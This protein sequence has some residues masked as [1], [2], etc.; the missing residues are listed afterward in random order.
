MN[1]STRHNGFTIVELLVVMAIIMLLLAMVIPAINK[2]VRSAYVATCSANLHEIYNAWMNQAI[3]YGGETRQRAISD[4]SQPGVPGMP[5]G[6]WTSSLR[7]YL[8][9]T[10]EDMAPALPFAASGWVGFTAPAIDRNYKVFICPEDDEPMVGVSGS[11]KV[12]SFDNQTYNH[13]MP[14]EVGVYTDIRNESG[15]PGKPG[16]YYELRFEDIRPN[17]GDYDRDDFIVHVTILE[18]GLVEASFYK[19]SAGY[20]FYVEDDMGITRIFDV[21]RVDP[22]GTKLILGGMA[23][24]A[25]NE[26]AGQRSDR[27]DSIFML[28][29]DLRTVACPADDNWWSPEFLPADANP[30]DPESFM[31][32]FARHTGHQVNVTW[33]DGSVH[34]MSPWDIDPRD[35]DIQQDMWE[36]GSRRGN[37]RTKWW[38]LP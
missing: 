38:N 31:P 5:G 9:T 21:G 30:S 7:P 8:M 27:S 13:H 6:D 14:I 23:S 36:T 10:P 1:R 37:Y 18:D 15:T 24:Y 12:L 35:I 28:D 17:G 25:I 33:R 11:I 29:Y 4:A 20:H 2:S 26:W 16:Y 19:G 22:N 32:T 3:Q 34:L